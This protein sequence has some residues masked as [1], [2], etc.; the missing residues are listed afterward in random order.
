MARINT[1]S[2][3]NDA[4]VSVQYDRLGSV[5]VGVQRAVQRNVL[6]DGGPVAAITTSVPAEFSDDGGLWAD[7][8]RA[9]I[10]NL[11]RSLREARDK[12]FGRDE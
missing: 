3:Q 10:N 8:N 7:L 12:A 2:P 1:Y 5:G 11:I 6:V 9:G 4:R